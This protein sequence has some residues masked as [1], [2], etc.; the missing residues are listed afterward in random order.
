M[1]VTMAVDPSPHIP[2]IHRVIHQMGIRGSD[3]EEAF[4]VGLVAITEAAQNFNPEKGVLVSWLAN[5]VRWQIKAW[6]YKERRHHHFSF[7][8]KE[9]GEEVMIEPEDNKNSLEFSEEMRE[10]LALVQKVCDETEQKVIISLALGYT[11]R[12]ICQKFGMT[13]VQVT[14]AK[15]RAR[16]KLEIARDA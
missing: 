4:S 1:N 10:T 2:L 14:R 11:G 3:A 16:Q 15:Q 13:P 7:M 6:Q 9:D 5:Y 8:R 12:E